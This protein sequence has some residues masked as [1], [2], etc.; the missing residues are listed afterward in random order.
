MRRRH[1]PHV[2]VDRLVAADAFERLLLEHAQELRLERRRHVADL[3]EQDRASAALLELADATPVGTR[4]GPTFVPEQLAFEQVL[5]HRGAVHRDERRLR[6]SAV[7]V[8]R[9]RYYLLAG[10]TFSRDEDRDVLRR[11]A[12][13]LLVDV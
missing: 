6:P 3:V 1:D 2:G 12:T 9:A 4:E 13:D 5:R 10:A 8:D 11:H 7:L